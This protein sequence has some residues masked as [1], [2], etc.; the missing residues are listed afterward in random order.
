M[1]SA[2]K[3][4]QIYNLPDIF[5]VHLKRFRH[6]ADYVSKISTLVKFPI[7][8]LDMS[9]HVLTTTKGKYDLYGVIN[10]SGTL[11]YGH[12]WANVWNET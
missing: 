6:H 7:L 3:L 5:I 1:V 8:D 10:H 2:K 4:Y 11:N 9:P 12:Y